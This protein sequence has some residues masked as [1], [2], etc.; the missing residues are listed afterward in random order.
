[1]PSTSPLASLAVIVT[2]A[3]RRSRSESLR[4]ITETRPSVTD[5]S[6]VSSTVGTAA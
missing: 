4:T 2:S 5:H 6:V 1:M 3:V